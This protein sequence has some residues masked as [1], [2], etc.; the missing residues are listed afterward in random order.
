M[1]IKAPWPG[2]LIVGLLQSEWQLLLDSPKKD[3]PLLLISS[4][5]ET[6]VRGLSQSKN[7]P[8]DQTEVKMS[9]N[10]WALELCEGV[11]GNAR[12]VLRAPHPAC[13]MRASALSL[14]S[15]S[16]VF[17][18]RAAPTSCAASACYSAWSSSSSSSS[19]PR[20]WT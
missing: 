18:L 16:S 8:E 4:V 1:L 20:R 17:Q 2:V 12:E 15:R 5:E 10:E 3:P 19:T 9:W 14:P 13:A 6:I 11:I 7:A